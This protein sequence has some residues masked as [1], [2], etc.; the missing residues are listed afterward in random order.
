MNVSF[1]NLQSIVKSFETVEIDIKD[2]T[3]EKV[4]IYIPNVEYCNVC[5]LKNQNGG[6][7]AGFRGA[8]IQR[9][10][11]LGSFFKRIARVAVPL[12]KRGINAIGQKAIETA[13][14]VGHDVLTGKN[15]KEAAKNR[16]RQAVNDLAKQGV[17][18]IKGQ[19]GGGPERKRKS[20]QGSRLKTGSQRK[21]ITSTR[22]SKRKTSPL[23]VMYRFYSP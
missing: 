3:Q 15:V 4:I 5:Y 18:N 14:K 23:D 8:R 17:N 7:L 10:Y 12:V 21:T 9:G 19:I 11:A 22:A 1:P 16:G 13:V 2:E 20:Q 6:A